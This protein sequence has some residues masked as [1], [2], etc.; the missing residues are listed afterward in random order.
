MTSDSI[1]C[2]AKAKLVNFVREDRKKAE[3]TK[4]YQ[5][6]CAL[7]PGVR[8]SRLWP[9][10]FVSDKF[11][12][13]WHTAPTQG[14]KEHMAFHLAYFEMTVNEIANIIS[15]WHWNEH[16]M[17]PPAEGALTELIM[18]KI[19]EAKAFIDER[20]QIAAHQ[21]SKRYEIDPQ[22]QERLKAR[23]RDKYR[24]LHPDYTPRQPA[25]LEGKILDILEM[26]ETKRSTLCELTEANPNTLKSCIKRLVEAGNIQRVK[27][28]CYALKRA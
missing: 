5:S 8:K 26:G 21:A 9:L 6:L 25:V 11:R 23:A 4:F 22:Y 28:G 24:E 10:V 7:M 1:Y 14:E 27:P 17:M 18:Q 20:K 13:R 2:T 12:E 16:D 19:T 3:R 15:T